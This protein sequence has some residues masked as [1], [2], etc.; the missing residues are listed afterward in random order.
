MFLKIILMVKPTNG[1]AKPLSDARNRQ[2]FLDK[3]YFYQ[4]NKDKVQRA[5]ARL[6]LFIVSRAALRSID[7]LREFRV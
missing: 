6:S 3:N 7:R 1:F 5:E 2:Y 4:D